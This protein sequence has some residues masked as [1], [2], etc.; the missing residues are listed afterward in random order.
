MDIEAAKYIGAGLAIGLG[1]IGPGIGE[2]IAAS[3]ALEA[4]G[5]NPEA[6]GKITPLMFVSMAI[7]ESTAIYALVVTMII[8]FA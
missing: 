3:K 4:I 2:G 7:T 6:A 8:L 1:A 5:R